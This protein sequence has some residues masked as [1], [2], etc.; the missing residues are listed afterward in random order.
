[1][2]L[3]WNGMFLGIRY[4]RKLFEMAKIKTEIVNR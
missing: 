1:M 2:D 3:K 4:Y